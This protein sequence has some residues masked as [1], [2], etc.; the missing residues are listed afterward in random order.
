MTTASHLNQIID[1]IVDIKPQRRWLRKKNRTTRS[2]RIGSPASAVAIAKRAGSS[3]TR[4]NQTAGTAA[5]GRRHVL[6]RLRL[7]FNRSAPHPYP[8]PHHRSRALPWPLL[9]SLDISAWLLPLPLLSRLRHP[10][11]LHCHYAPLFHLLCRLPH[12]FSPRGHRPP[13]RP[14]PAATLPMN[15]TFPTAAAGLSS[16]SWMNL[17][18]SS[19][20]PMSMI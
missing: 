3:A 13:R 8:H 19:R 17:P 10:R 9:L 2:G 4:P 15:F 18:S 14:P 11:S 16:S 5:C 7:T 1:Q 20:V 6:I 12:S